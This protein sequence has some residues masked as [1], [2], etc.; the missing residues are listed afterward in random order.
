MAV[1]ASSAGV[2]SPERNTA[3][4]PALRSVATTASGTLSCSNVVTP[5]NAWA[6]SIR[7]RMFCWG[8][9]LIWSRLMP[10]RIMPSGCARKTSSAC[11]DIQTSRSIMVPASDG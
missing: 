8:N 7:R 9:A 5:V 4:L 10:E 11:R 2:S 3:G 1:E 6:R